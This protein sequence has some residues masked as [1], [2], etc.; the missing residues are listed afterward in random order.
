MPDTPRRSLPTFSLRALLGLVLLAAVLCLFAAR[1]RYA[2]NRARASACVGYMKHV[3]MGILE[4][5]SVFRDFPRSAVATK[6]GQ[7]S[8]SWR[9]IVLPYY[10]SMGPGPRYDYSQPWDSTTNAQFGRFAYRAYRWDPAQGAGHDLHTNVVGIQGPDALFDDGRTTPIEISPAIED[11]IILIEVRDSGIHWMEPRDLDYR[12]L[13]ERERKGALKLGVMDD[14]F[15][16]LF[17][18]GRVWRLRADT[19]RDLLLKFMTIEGAKRHDAEQ[20]L[21]AH[22][23]L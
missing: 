1:V 11:L 12:E 22:R 20:V 21:G 2:Q 18:D 5:E 4:Y 8:C 10:E 9:T 23:C 3:G 19:P 16:V 17:L 7:P 14:G 6:A 15:C 13:I